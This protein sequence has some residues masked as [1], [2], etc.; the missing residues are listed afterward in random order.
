M[1]TTR[2]KRNKSKPVE[3]NRKQTSCVDD[4]HHLIETR[5]CR[6]VLDLKN[7]FSSTVGYNIKS[8]DILPQET[9]LCHWPVSGDPQEV[10]AHCEY[11]MHL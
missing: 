8:S 3:R 2:D 7:E 9:C 6:K 1:D 5:I 11:S 10:K 4:L